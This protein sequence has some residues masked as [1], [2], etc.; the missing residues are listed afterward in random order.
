MNSISLSFSNKKQSEILKLTKE[1]LESSSI[2]AIPNI[3]RNK[4]YSIKIMWLICLLISSG[5]C[6]FFVSK[7]IGDFLDYDVTTKT[8]IKYVN[9]ILFP[10]VTIC[11]L[12]AFASPF[13]S[14]IAKKVFESLQLMNNSYEDAVY[15]S[16]IK[17]KLYKTL[18]RGHRF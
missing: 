2:H 10:I 8:Q 12:N 9:K 3:T 17:T 4:F 16:K 18:K 14:K 13:P 11:D 5:Y 7:S 15:Y 1:T 6:G